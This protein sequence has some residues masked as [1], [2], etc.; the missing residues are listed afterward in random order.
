MKE[1]EYDITAY[2]LGF[3]LL[4]IVAAVHFGHTLM[5]LI[6]LLFFPGVN[7]TVVKTEHQ[8]KEKDS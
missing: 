4:L 7:V 5:P 3:V 6:L 8:K 2:V 1:T